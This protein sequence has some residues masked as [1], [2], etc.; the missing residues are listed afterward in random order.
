MWEKLGNV[1]KIRKC[2]K[3]QEMWE[4]LGNVEKIREC[5]KNQEIW[6]IKIKIG[7]G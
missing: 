5:G 7:K 3:N 4:K 2:G 1:G 6:E